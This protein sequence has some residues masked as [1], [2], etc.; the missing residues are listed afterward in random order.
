ME[1]MSGLSALMVQN[2]FSDEDIEFI[3]I[4]LFEIIGDN[5]EEYICRYKNAHEYNAEEKIPNADEFIN[6]LS[7]HAL[8]DRKR[9]NSNQV[10]FINQYIFGLMIAY[11]IINHQLPVSDLKGKYLDIAV[12]SY[13]SYGK[14]AGKNSILLSNL[15]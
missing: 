11:S 8:L 15:L 7:H 3:N 5:I 1:I 6:K 10:G 12:S 4:C 2:D 13:S 9:D 14:K